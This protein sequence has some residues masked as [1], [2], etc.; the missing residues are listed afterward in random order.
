MGSLKTLAL[1]YAPA[2]SRWCGPRATPRPEALTG[3]AADE[4]AAATSPVPIRDDEPSVA[5]TPASL[6][7]T[8]EGGDAGEYLYV[9]DLTA[10]ELYA[11]AARRRPCPA[12]WIVSDD[13]T[14]YPFWGADGGPMDGRGKIY[15]VVRHHETERTDPEIVCA[16][17]LAEGIMG[18]YGIFLAW[19]AETDPYGEFVSVPQAAHRFPHVTG[20][21]HLSSAV[22]ICRETIVEGNRLCGLWAIDDRAFRTRPWTYVGFSEVTDPEQFARL[23]RRLGPLPG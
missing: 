19:V 23:Y 18:S 13:W 16:R 20:T 21:T 12:L 14:R 15:R 9:P 2:F 6:Y 10:Y 8:A 1:E 17:L 3:P 22:P 4:S 5:A 11:T 7:R